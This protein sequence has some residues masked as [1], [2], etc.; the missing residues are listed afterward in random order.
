MEIKCDY[1]DNYYPDTK[2]ECPFCGAINEYARTNVKSSL[3][4]IYQFQQ[5]YKEMNLPP[6]EITRFFIGLNIKEPKAFGIY[7]DE[8]NRTIVYKNKADGTRVIRYA[9][10]DEAYGV[11]ELYLRLQAE[12]ANQKRR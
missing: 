3:Q 4:T 2:T 5:W 9:G 12:I 10:M 11:N 8:K 1:C 7:K 6:M